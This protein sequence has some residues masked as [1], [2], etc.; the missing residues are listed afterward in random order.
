MSAPSGVVVYLADGVEVARR[1]EAGSADAVEGGLVAALD[2][3][4]LTCVE[5]KFD[6]SR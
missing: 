3:V 2:I 4:Y 6:A 5:H 1:L